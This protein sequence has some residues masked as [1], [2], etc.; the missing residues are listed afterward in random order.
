MRLRDV[1]AVHLVECEGEANCVRRH[2]ACVHPTVAGDLLGQDRLAVSTAMPLVAR[3]G[4][5]Q[6]RVVREVD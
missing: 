4:G 6:C 2:L 3:V 1:V 5:H